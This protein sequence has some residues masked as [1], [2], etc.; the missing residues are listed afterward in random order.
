MN[1]SFSDD[2]LVQRGVY[3]RKNVKKLKMAIISA[4]ATYIRKEEK[5]PSAFL[6][7]MCSPFLYQICMCWIYNRCSGITDKVKQECP[8][9]ATQEVDAAEECPSGKIDDQCFEVVEKDVIFITQYT[10]LQGVQS[11]LFQQE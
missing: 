10:N 11:M 5:L 8:L 2:F 4:R 1:G 7:K 9:C 3:H 6:L